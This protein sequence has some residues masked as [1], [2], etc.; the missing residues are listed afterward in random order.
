MIKNKMTIEELAIIIA[1]G[2]NDIEH[3]MATKQDLADLRQS[4]EK[5][6]DRLDF[7]IDNLAEI[8]QQ[9]DEVDIRELQHRVMVLEKKFRSTKTP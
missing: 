5:K 2:F 6:I 7:K 4:L 8:V 1:K 9:L 3:R